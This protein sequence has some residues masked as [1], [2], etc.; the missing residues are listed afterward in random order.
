LIEKSNALLEAL[1]YR[2]ISSSEYDI[3]FSE[4]EKEAMLLIDKLP[5]NFE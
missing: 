4:L 2:K 5:Q 3:K 1:D